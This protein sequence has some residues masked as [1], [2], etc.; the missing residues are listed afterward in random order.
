MRCANDCTAPAPVKLAETR[1]GFI[2]VYSCARFSAGEGPGAGGG[3]VG[4]EDDAVGVDEAVD[5]EAM[6]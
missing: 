2:E 1:S 4:C 3:G 6:G 5:V